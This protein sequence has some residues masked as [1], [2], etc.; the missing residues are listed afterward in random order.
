MGHLPAVDRAV[1]EATLGRMLAEAERGR[2]GQEASTIHEIVNEKV[3]AALGLKFITE[4]WAWSETRDR[5]IKR[6]EFITYTHEWLLDVV[7]S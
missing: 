5:E 4:G 2:A 3:T 6:Y 7:D 1:L